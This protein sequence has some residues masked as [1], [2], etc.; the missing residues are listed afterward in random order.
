MRSYISEIIPENETPF[1]TDEIYTIH[2]YEQLDHNDLQER[3]YMEIQT[4]N[5]S[6][7]CNRDYI[8]P[9]I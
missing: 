3:A 1:N 9:T 6:D 4:M 7:D 2:E 8:T 5:A